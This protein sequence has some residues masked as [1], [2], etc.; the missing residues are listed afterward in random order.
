ML[1]S[2][3]QLHEL[4]YL[5]I[6]IAARPI[7]PNADESVPFNFNGVNIAEGV[8]LTEV[9]EDK[10]D[11][12]LFVLKFRILIEN[13]EGKIAP[14]DIDIDAAGV[15]SVNPSLPLAERQEFVLINGCSVLYGAIRD[16]IL[17]LTARSARGPLLL[18][19]VNFLDYKGKANH[20]VN[21]KL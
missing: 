21:K 14:Y 8:D 3:L 4:Y 16:Q 7:T 10:E 12:K 6:K 18:P 9:D 2:K 13:K 17:T 11:P 5:S 15:F 1:P 19:T 20:V